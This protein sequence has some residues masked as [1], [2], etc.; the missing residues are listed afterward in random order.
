MLITISPAKTLDY[1]S[2]LATTE[3]SQPT[4]LSQTEQLIQICGKL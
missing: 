1:E 2:P 4:L 3:Y